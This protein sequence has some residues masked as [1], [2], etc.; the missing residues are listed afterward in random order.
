M[1]KL[2]H[3]TYIS[4]DEESL[5]VTSVSIEGGHDLTLDINVLSYQLQNIVKDAKFQCS[6]NAINKNS[7]LKYCH[8]VIKRI[9]E[10]ENEHEIQTR[11]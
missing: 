6:D 8:G 1:K 5:I 3:Q 7:P 9:D 4:R 2:G 11:K 10:K